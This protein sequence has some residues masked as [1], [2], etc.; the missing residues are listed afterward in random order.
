M[1]RGIADDAAHDER[2]SQYSDLHAKRQRN[3][4]GDEPA[5]TAIE[6]EE[7]HEAQVALLA[8]IGWR[9]HLAFGDDEHAGETLRE[10]DG[11]DAPRAERWIVYE[12]VPAEPAGVHDIVVEIPMQDRWRFQRIQ[13]VEFYPGRIGFE[14][15]ALQGLDGVRHAGAPRRDRNDLP[16]HR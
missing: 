11:I 1:T 9:R 8:D 5:I 14:S 13:I 16:Q 15:D 10:L 7:V 4:F 6:L 2:Q 3:D 12:I